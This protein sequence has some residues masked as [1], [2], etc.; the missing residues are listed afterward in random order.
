MC[1]SVN[2]EDFYKVHHEMGHVE[3]FMSYKDQP[4]VFRTG[5]HS[6]FH[7][8]IGDTIALSVFTRKHMKQLGFIDDETMSYG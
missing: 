5:A 6:A 4:T 1:T 2:A 7:E 3:Y 8:A